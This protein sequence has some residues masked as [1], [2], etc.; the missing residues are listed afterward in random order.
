MPQ[1]EIEGGEPINRNFLAL[2]GKDTGKELFEKYQEKIKQEQKAKEALEARRFSKRRTSGFNN[3]LI[4]FAE[5]QQALGLSPKTTNLEDA[6]QGSR[7]PV[8][9]IS[10]GEDSK[11]AG[12][13]LD[14]K[15]LMRNFVSGRQNLS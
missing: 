10:T 8:A 5:Q 12:K 13:S 9:F 11:Q 4:Q 7:G 2:L 1:F 6:T 15:S 14:K 3:E